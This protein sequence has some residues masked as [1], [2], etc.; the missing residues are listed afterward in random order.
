MSV[1]EFDNR[2]SRAAAAAVHELLEH[3]G[4]VVFVA[5]CHADKRDGFHAA[6]KAIAGSEVW[7]REV[8]AVNGDERITTTDGGELYFIAASATGGRAVSADVLFIADHLLH[9]HQGAEILAA[10]VGNSRI[11]TF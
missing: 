11:I 5:A 7:I 3:S 1:H 2:V 9:G 6:R 4:R 10:F 8:R